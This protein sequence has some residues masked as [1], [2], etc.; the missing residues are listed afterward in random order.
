MLVQPAHKAVR[1]ESIVVG[2]QV[3]RTRTAHGDLM[4][5]VEEIG[6]E[7]HA[8]RKVY[9]WF[10]TVY[11]LEGEKTGPKALFLGD[12]TALPVCRGVWSTPVDLRVQ[13]GVPKD[14]IP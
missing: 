3:F 5:V 12:M 7:V 6:Q 9:V 11:K 10:G 4:L 1:P 2:D 8:G 13:K 14:E